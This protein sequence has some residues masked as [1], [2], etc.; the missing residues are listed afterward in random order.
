MKTF[1]KT[2]LQRYSVWTLNVVITFSINIVPT[3]SENNFEKRCDNV[4]VCVYCLT[5]SKH[6][7]KT[8]FHNVLKNILKIF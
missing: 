7:S 8:L 3:R 4:Y 6:F 1:Q 2:I 5:L